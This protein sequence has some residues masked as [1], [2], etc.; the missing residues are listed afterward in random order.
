MGDTSTQ[1]LHLQ[2]LIIGK[3][4]KR[5]GVGGC[6]GLNKPGKDRRRAFSYKYFVQTSDLKGIPVCD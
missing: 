3:D 5:L 2:G 4:P 1:N 6:L